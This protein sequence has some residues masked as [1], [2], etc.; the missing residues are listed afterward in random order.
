MFYFFANIQTFM[1]KYKGKSF[2]WNNPFKYSLT[3][4]K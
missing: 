3:F 1:E 4:G 2:F